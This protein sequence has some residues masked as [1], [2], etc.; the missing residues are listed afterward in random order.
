MF[1]VPGSSVPPRNDDTVDV[2]SLTV[3]DLRARKTLLQIQ[4]KRKGERFP[5]WLVL[6]HLPVR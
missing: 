1:K 3:N 6:T 4:K 5:H 2:N